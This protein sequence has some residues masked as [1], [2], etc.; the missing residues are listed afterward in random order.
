MHVVYRKYGTSQLSILMVGILQCIAE[1][2]TAILNLTIS[3]PNHLHP[4]AFVSFSNFPVRQE[5]FL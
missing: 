4:T 2:S 3:D 1:E 5:L